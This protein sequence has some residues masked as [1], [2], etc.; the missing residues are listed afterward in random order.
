MTMK[1]TM[2]E[3]NPNHFITDPNPQVQTGSLEELMRTVAEISNDFDSDNYD[4]ETG[5]VDRDPDLDNTEF[6]TIRDACFP[7]A[8]RAAAG[9]LQLF[10]QDIQPA[11]IIISPS[12]GE[13]CSGQGNGVEFGIV[14]DSYLNEHHLQEVTVDFSGDIVND[15]WTNITTLAGINNGNLYAHDWANSLNDDELW[16]RVLCQDTGDCESIIYM[17]WISVDSTSPV[18]SNETY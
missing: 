7:A 16:I 10:Y 8:M 3:I 9:V 6:M 1:P 11:A 18:I 2:A 4:G 15:P 12:Q 14:A 13:I 5:A 17:H